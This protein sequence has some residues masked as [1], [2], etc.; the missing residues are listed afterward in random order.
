MTS[1]DVNCSIS[2]IYIEAPIQ[3]KKTVKKTRFQLPYWHKDAAAHNN[4]RYMNK[5]D[6]VQT[7]IED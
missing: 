1:D 7:H 6:V 2:S 5:L 3:R 4:L